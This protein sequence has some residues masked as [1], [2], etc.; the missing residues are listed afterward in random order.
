M[1]KTLYGCH[2]VASHGAQCHTCG[3]GL[4]PFPYSRVLHTYVGAC[5]HACMHARTHAHTHSLS[6]G[7]SRDSSQGRMGTLITVHFQLPG[8]NTLYGA[9]ESVSRAGTPQ[10]IKGAKKWPVDT[11]LLSTRQNPRLTLDLPL[12]PQ[13]LPDHL[14]KS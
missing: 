4:L 10:P 5:T 14:L 11:T 1:N 7:S 3:D 6:S 13:T 12:L 2:S 8:S 9:P